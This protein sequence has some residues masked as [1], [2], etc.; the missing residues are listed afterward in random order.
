MKSE[1]EYNNFMI[2]ISSLQR[3]RAIHAKDSIKMINKIKLEEIKNTNRASRDV[4][5]VQMRDIVNKNES[6]SGK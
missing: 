5:A 3:C 1:G 4:V 2:F 6:A